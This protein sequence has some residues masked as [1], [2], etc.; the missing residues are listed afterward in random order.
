MAI[1]KGTNIKVP[2]SN[3][4]TCREVGERDWTITEKI[5]IISVYS[6]NSKT[7][8]TVGNLQSQKEY[9]EK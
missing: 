2:A 4:T 3:M 9:H 6:G 5:L 1:L 8:L 7:R